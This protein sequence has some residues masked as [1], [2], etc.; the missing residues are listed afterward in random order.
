[1]RAACLQGTDTKL[2]NF[3]LF[4]D[5]NK[6]GCDCNTGLQLSL[7]LTGQ[8]KII[9]RDVPDNSGQLATLLAPKL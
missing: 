9:I 6:K 3:S 1:M 5:T 2:L 7:T 4:T 8:I